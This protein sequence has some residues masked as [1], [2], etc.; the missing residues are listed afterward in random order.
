MKLHVQLI[1]NE[2]F[3]EMY[4]HYHVT[5][6]IE[7]PEDSFENNTMKE[8]KLDL[9]SSPRSCITNHITPWSRFILEKLI[10][11]QPVKIFPFFHGIR[12]LI[13][14]SHLRF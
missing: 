4:L 5:Q 12:G 7:V 1:S 11:A 14:T 2:T 10:V 8:N 13:T 9:L 6:I 3:L